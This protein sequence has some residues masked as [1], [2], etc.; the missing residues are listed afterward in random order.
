MCM[1]VWVS[2]TVVCMCSDGSWFVGGWEGEGLG[3]YHECN[4]EKLTWV[5]V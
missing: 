4:P 2:V 3:V 1:G 5:Q